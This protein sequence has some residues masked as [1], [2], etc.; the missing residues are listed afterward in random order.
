MVVLLMPWGRRVKKAPYIRLYCGWWTDSRVLGISAEA[1]HV[2]LRS[3]AY[4]KNEALDGLLPEHALLLLF[5]KI[6]T[7]PSI[8]TAE[9]VDAGLWIETDK[10]WAIRRWAEYQTTT[11]EDDASRENT[12]ARK[13]RQ[14]DRERNA[15]TNG[16]TTGEKLEQS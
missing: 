9:L 14:R 3:I 11:D 16:H 1:E 4:S 13:Q 7:P 2:W 15:D 12:R 8:V 5:P 10:G 6:S